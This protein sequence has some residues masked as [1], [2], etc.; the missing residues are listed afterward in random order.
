MRKRNPASTNPLLTAKVK[1][2]LDHELSTTSVKH[3]KVSPA[4]AVSIWI[5]D[6][7]SD[8][9]NP[10]NLSVRFCLERSHNKA[11]ERELEK[12]LWIMDGKHVQSDI[13]IHSKT[14]V[15]V[16]DGIMDAYFMLLNYKTLFQLLFRQDCE[17]NL[18]FMEW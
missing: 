8:N 15:Y 13:Q 1:Q 5:G 12:G 4:L 18:F 16:Q 17:I 2:L 14:M 6:L 7:I 3:F 9:I 10:S 11:K